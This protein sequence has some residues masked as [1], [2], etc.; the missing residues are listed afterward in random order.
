[1][2]IGA[3]IRQGQGNTLLETPCWTPIAEK[4]VPSSTKKP[5]QK[6]LQWTPKK[7]IGTYNILENPKVDTLRTK[8]L[9]SPGH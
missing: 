4:K 6:I 5:A 8:F 1:M 7:L 9:D 3:S 2:S